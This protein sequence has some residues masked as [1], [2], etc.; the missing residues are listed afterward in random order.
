MAR[1]QEPVTISIRAKAG[2]RDLIDQAARCQGRSRSD[3]MIDAARRAAEKA[4]LDKPPAPTDRLRRTLKARA[5]W[6]TTAAPVKVS[7]R[8]VK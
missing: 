1:T 6:D 4:L 8:R 5:P 7:G 3:F 2:Q